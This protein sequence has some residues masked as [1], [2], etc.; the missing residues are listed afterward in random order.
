M[1]G[2]ILITKNNAMNNLYEYKG[3][4]DSEVAASVD[5]YSIDTYGGNICKYL[6][7]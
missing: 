5:G 7:I 3:R 2:G 6:K 1:G 4:G